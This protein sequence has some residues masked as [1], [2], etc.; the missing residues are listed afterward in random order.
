MADRCP[1]AETTA[2][3]HGADDPRLIQSEGQHRQLH[4]LGKR[5][6]GVRGDGDGS[7]VDAGLGFRWDMNRQPAL[8]EGAGGHGKRLQDIG[9]AHRVLVHLEDVDL[10]LLVD[11]H[12][13]V[14]LE[15]QLRGEKL[16]I[17]E[18]DI[19]TGLVPDLDDAE[20]KGAARDDAAGADQVAGGHFYPVQALQGVDAEAGRFIFAG[21]GG[22]S[23]RRSGQCVRRQLMRQ[24]LLVSDGRQQ[25]NL[26]IRD[27]RLSAQLGLG[28]PA[29]EVRPGQQGGGVLPAL[30]EQVAELFPLREQVDGAFLCQCLNMSGHLGQL[31]LDGGG[32]VL[33]LAQFRLARQLPQLVLGVLQGGLGLLQR[34]LEFRLA[35]DVSRYF[36]IDRFLAGGGPAFQ[37]HQLAETIRLMEAGKGD[38]PAA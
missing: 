31:L 6:A 18:I 5:R 38:G 25:E 7:A 14:V 29:I 4:R 21:A 17:L 24:A 2:I 1:F 23:H 33:D 22:Q 32:G 10:A 28:Q 35:D 34:R 11:L 19:A 16:Q 15:Q 9:V 8:L 27:R 30:A 26:E 13:A 37:K 3:I 36:G 12:Q 20:V